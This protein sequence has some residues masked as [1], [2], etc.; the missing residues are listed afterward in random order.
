M[1]P[2]GRKKRKQYEFTKRFSVEV[3][4]VAGSDNKYNKDFHPSSYGFDKDFVT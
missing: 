3:M 2:R 1:K 4:F